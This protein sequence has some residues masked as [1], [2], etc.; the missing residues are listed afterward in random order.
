[1]RDALC[2]RL[3]WT[4]VY[5]LFGRDTRELAEEM[6]AGGLRATLCCVDT[7]QLDGD[8]SGAPFDARLLAALPVGVDP[9]GERG[10]FHTCVHAGP[11]FGD[12]LALRSAERL[13]RDDRF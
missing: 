7:Q 3:G 13:L 10:E 11:M 4:P 2:A 9:C 12:P 8:F 6:I 1:Y 5:P